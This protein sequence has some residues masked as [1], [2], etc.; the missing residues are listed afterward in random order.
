MPNTRP[1]AR[2]TLRLSKTPSSYRTITNTNGP[3]TDARAIPNPY[4]Q[5]RQQHFIR[6][7]ATVTT[8]WGAATAWQWYNDEPILR[9]VHAEEPEKIKQLEFE[10]GRRQA[11][12]KEDNRDLISSQHLQVKKSWENPGVYA[13]GFNKGRVVAPDSD[14]AYIKT[15]RRIHFFDGKLLKDIKLDRN[16]AAAI[17][18]KG[19]LLQW[20]T[21]FA[22]DSKQPAYTLR[23]KNLVSL[24]LSRDRIIALS[25]SGTVYSLPVS[26]KDQETG[27]K[28]SESSWNPLWS[29]TASLS[30]RTH[31]PQSLSWNEK[32]TDISSGLEHALLRTSQGRVF[33]FASGSQ[34]FPSRGQL[35]IPGLTWETRPAGAFD[36]PHEIASLKDFTIAKIAT[37]DNHSLVADSSGRVFAFGD[38]SAG[39]LGFN[40]NPESSY[41]DTPSLLP[42]QRLYNGTAQRPA[43]TNVFAGGNTSFFTVDAVKMSTPENPSPRDLGRVTADTLA[44]GFGLTGQLGNGRYTHNQTTLTKVPAFSGLF[45]FDENKNS[46]V[47]IR[48]SY[49][50]VGQLHAA[51]VLDNLSSTSVGPVF[52]GL[53][54]GNGKSANDINWGRDILFWGN[55]EFYQI[56]TGKRSNVA[57]PTY[58]QPLDAKAEAERASSVLGGLGLASGKRK[59]TAEKE[60]HRF[61]IT[62]KTKVKVGGRT[63]DTEQ[64]VECGRGVTA[65]YSA[66]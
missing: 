27:P 23:G 61:Q 10:A 51:A 42:I 56:G 2:A 19:D 28:L 52:S 35:G 13:W 65:V 9:E 21:A 38:N 20:G 64:R 37:G 43:V 17:D 63:V 11:T 24:A 58:L 26:Q 3:R 40:Y 48:L 14:E 32:V 66:V 34:D 49:L 8:L 33:S 4:A 60:M 30:Y 54:G 5:R 18:E 15:P 46:I 29:S 44:C 62:P 1:L 55:N 45:E 12:S 22:P 41:L 31:T 7:I 36:Q 16:F 57:T 47:P 53:G 59:E 6:S 50:S 39:Q 25:S